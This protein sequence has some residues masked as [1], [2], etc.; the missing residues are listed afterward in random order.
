M[1]PPCGSVLSPKIS[2]AG[3]G[4]SPSDTPGIAFVETASGRRLRRRLRVT[5]MI[6]LCRTTASPI[7]NSPIHMSLWPGG[8][9]KTDSNLEALRPRISPVSSHGGRE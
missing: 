6:I 3:S 5:A 4:S 2:E 7:H 8:R 1:P 9:W